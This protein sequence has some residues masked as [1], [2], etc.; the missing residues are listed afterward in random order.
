MLLHPVITPF[1]WS[2]FH[3]W[4][5]VWRE[6]LATAT[7]GTTTI[8]PNPKKRSTLEKKL[9]DVMVPVGNKTMSTTTSNVR[10]SGNKD[11]CVVMVGTML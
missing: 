10:S 5:Q 4:L 9:P 7:K 11:T 6:A 2:F 3:Q 1:T 8:Q